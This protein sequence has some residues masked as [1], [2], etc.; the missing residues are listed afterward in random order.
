MTLVSSPFFLKIQTSEKRRVYLK[1]EREFKSLN[2]ENFAGRI[3][4]HPSELLGLASTLCTIGA[5]F[6]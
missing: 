2:L 1:L 4:R 3:L 6:T 5:Y